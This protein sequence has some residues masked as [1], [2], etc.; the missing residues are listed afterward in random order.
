MLAR[1]E[2]LS[3]PDDQFV[4]KTDGPN[5]DCL[6]KFVCWGMEPAR[7]RERRAAL[8]V[9][10]DVSPI[11]PSA[12]DGDLYGLADGVARDDLEIKEG[13]E[14]GPVIGPPGAN[15]EGTVPARARRV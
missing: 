4:E 2:V 15:R 8:L 10:T 6:T 14:L 1:V 13:R 11:S 5:G 12:G 9:A 7:R 3:R